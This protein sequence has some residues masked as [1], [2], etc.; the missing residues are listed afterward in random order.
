[1]VF[2]AFIFLIYRLRVILS[3]II[4]AILQADENIFVLFHDFLKEEKAEI[5]PLL[6]G[7]FAFLEAVVVVVVAF[8][9]FLFH[10]FN[11]SHS[12]FLS[13][14]FF[15]FYSFLFFHASK[16]CARP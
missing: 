16:R 4:L 8:D 14:Y 6:D 13:R 7:E 10:G 5:V 3:R 15:H 12:P 2:I 11:V 9:E 1:M